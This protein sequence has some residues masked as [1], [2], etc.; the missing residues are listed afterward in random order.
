M[1][2]FSRILFATGTVS[3]L[4]ISVANGSDPIRVGPKKI[5]PADVHVGERFSNV[6][7]IAVDGRK[8]DLSNCEDFKATVIA[9]TSTSCP[10]CRKYAPS[11]AQIEKQF[12][13]KNIRFC[14][15]NSIAS[16]KTDDIKAVIKTNEL[17]GP[18]LHDQDESL[19]HTLKAHTTAEVFVF[20]SAQTLVYRG[21]VDDQFG[22][23]PI[24]QGQEQRADVTA[25]HVR[26]RRK[27]QA[28]RQRHFKQE[29][30]CRRRVVHGNVERLISLG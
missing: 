20:D 4:F 10:I 27:I 9:L 6:S 2:C 23:V 12:T 15:L 16:D 19:V 17:S 7:G 5:K 14:F 26:V 8:F 13:S 21:A 18:Y 29:L 30:V 24:E 11:L 1:S 3:L 25:V 22:H 28:H